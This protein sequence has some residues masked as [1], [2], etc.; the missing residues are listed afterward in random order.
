MPASFL[1]FSSFHTVRKPRAGGGFFFSW[2]SYMITQ[3]ATFHTSILLYL[4]GLTGISHR[5]NYRAR[6]A[7][8]LPPF[9]AKFYSLLTPLFDPRSITQLRCPGALG[10]WP[11]IPPRSPQPT[12]HCAAFQPIARV[13]HE[14]SPFFVNSYDACFTIKENHVFSQNL[15]GNA[16]SN[17]QTC[18][19]RNTRR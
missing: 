12:T 8:N 1:F 13:P 10:W 15:N 11:H 6:K 18:H 16:T 19:E 2:W 3:R 17:S 5:S 9:G 14:R 7:S 4:N